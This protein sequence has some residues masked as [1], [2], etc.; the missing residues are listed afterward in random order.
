MLWKT[1]SERI[2]Y[3]YLSCSGNETSLSGCSY[4]NPSSYLNYWYNDIRA[5][6]QCQMK[7]Q[8]GMVLLIITIY[9]YHVHYFTESCTN[10]GALRLS[11]GNQLNEGR[12]EICLDGYWGSVCSN[13]WDEQDA[14]VTCR[15][16]GYQTLS[17]EFTSQ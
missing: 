4:Q 2:G 3:R 15:Q 11:G 9:I 5:G 8:S 13:G 7:S 12:V 16:A 1:K 17:E 10:V 6:V 14:L